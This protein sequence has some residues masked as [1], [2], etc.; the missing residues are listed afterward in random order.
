MAKRIFVSRS[1]WGSARTISNAQ[2]LEQL[3]VARGF[4]PVHPEAF[5][6]PAQAR[7]FRAA[8]IVLGEDGSGLHNVMF[9]EPGCVLGVIS[10][11]DRINLWHMAI[12]QHLGHKLCYV[13]A[14]PAADG[15]RTVDEAA[16]HGMIDV[17][18]AAAG[19]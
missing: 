13:P 16:F 7:I 3:A 8:R 9:A 19:G 6:L 15:A 17:L 10:V 5:S 11:L 1:R 12:C 2:R 14:G 18:D 4:L